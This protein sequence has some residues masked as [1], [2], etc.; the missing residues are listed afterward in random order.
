MGGFGFEEVVHGVAVHF[1]GAAG[2]PGLAVEADEAG[3]GRVFIAGAAGDEDGAGDEGE[4]VVFLEEDDDA[5][6]E[7]DAL[8]LLGFEVVE[9]GDG[10]FLPG[11]VLLGGR[12]RVRRA[13][14]TRAARKRR[15]RWIWRCG[16]P[17]R[18]KRLQ[19]KAFDKRKP[20]YKLW[21]GL[22]PTK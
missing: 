11:L 12:E 16:L 15:R 13:G 6:F 22:K 19:G 17:R 9:R 1:G 14:A 2:A 18:M 4:L 10:D 20:W 3:F 7:L 21:H 8:G 5:V